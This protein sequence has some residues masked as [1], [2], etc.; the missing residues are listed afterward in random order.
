VWTARDTELDRTVAVKVPRRGGLTSQEVEQFLRE[1][2]AVAQL[3]HP[4]I[5]SVHEVGRDGD[6]VFIVTDLVHGVT[7]NEWLTAKQPTFREVAELCA[8]IADALHHAHEAGVIHR[9][10]KPRNILM[11][12][13]DGMAR[14][15]RRGAKLG[16]DEAGLDEPVL[17][18]FGL[19]RREAGEVTVTLEGQVLGTPAYMSPE[20]ARGEAH[21]AD[22][23]TDVYSLGVILFELLSGEIPFRGA[24]RM[25]LH[26][27]VHDEPRHPRSL[28]D[29]IPKDLATICLKAMAK[30]ASRRYATARD[31]ADDLRRYLQGEP[32]HARPVG[33]AERAWRWCRRNPVVAGLST[34][35]VVSIGAVLLLLALYATRERADATRERRRTRMDHPVRRFD[36][37]GDP[38][39]SRL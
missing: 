1:A 7:L 8:K 19:A 38:L 27:V 17:M 21:Q 16:R 26:E 15:E 25:L 9:D 5:V 11:A 33:R 34:G 37:Y 10:L 29:R 14:V 13:R 31:M 2:R 20:Q 36:W 22:R 35:V 12:R 6:T 28:N 24:T 18:D 4:N 3:R 39:S 23:R 30:E 32:I